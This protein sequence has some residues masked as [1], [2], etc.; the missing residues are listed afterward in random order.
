ML[1]QAVVRVVVNYPANIVAPN[2]EQAEEQLEDRIAQ[3]LNKIGYQVAE[4]ETTDF[5]EHAYPEPNEQELR[6]W[7]QGHSLLAATLYVKRTNQNFQ[8]ALD[9][10]FDRLIWIE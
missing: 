5:S 3:K 1:Y 2:E 4:V 6:Y 9:H 10:V 8:D 7:R